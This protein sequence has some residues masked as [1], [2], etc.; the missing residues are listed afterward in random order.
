MDIPVEILTVAHMHGVT[1][2]VT[3]GATL[4]GS[5]KVA[6]NTQTG[7]VLDELVKSF[8]SLSDPAAVVGDETA[9]ASHA[10]ALKA[11]QAKLGS[12]YTVSGS[13][14]PTS[15]LH[16][17]VPREGWVLIGA[18][19]GFAHAFQLQVKSSFGFVDQKSVY[20][21]NGELISVDILVVVQTP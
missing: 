19:E 15:D 18:G 14:L 4:D 12:D 5:G 10:I 2:D 9:A 21:L 17:W 11:V 20:Y 6:I 7:V 3:V 1:E 13:A 16:I 8:A